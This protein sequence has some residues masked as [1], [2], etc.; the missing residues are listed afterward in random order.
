MKK[1]KRGGCFVTLILWF[2]IFLPAVRMILSE[3]PVEK[4]LFRD[5]VENEEVLLSVLNQD[6]AL[7]PDDFFALQS[8][9]EDQKGFWQAD[10]HVYEPY[11][12]NSVEILEQFEVTAN[13]VR[14]ETKGKKGQKYTIS[15]QLYWAE[16]YSEVGVREENQV[17]N[18]V[19]AFLWYREKNE[20]SDWELLELVIDFV[21]QIPYE[22]PENRY[23]IYTP[24][25]ILYRNTGDCDSKSIFAAIILKQLGYDVAIFYSKEYLHAMLGVNTQSTGYYKELDGK[26]Y[27]FTEMTAPGWQIGDLPADCPDPEKWFLSKI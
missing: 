24:T 9:W 19:Q 22:I 14:V 12:I 10:W 16:V 2:I 20:L 23:G 5:Y 25:E 11:L 3:A 26:P 18:I 13:K 7:Y 15:P 17:E 21:Q 27:Y 6:N 4:P 8:Q 1:K